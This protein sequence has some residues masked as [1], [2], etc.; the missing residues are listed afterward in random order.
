M[1]AHRN[2]Q[3]RYEVQKFI[4]KDPRNDLIK[5]IKL[6]SNIDSRLNAI[7]D[8]IAAMRGSP[9]PV[10]APAPQINRRP[11]GASG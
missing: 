1:S 6:T 9:A 2:L 10:Q 8:R 5:R 3:R 11:A 4:N 7:S